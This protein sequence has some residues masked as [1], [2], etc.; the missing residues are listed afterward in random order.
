MEP[1][2][3]AQTDAMTKLGLSRR[4]YSEF[5]GREPLKKNVVDWSLLPQQLI[6][7]GD[8][9]RVAAEFLK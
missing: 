6:E 2:E 9:S 4:R 1:Y 8:T 7:P 3:G 5:G